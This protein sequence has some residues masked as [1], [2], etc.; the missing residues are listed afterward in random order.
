MIINMRK[1]LVVMIGTIAIAGSLVVQSQCHC[2]GQQSQVL[3]IN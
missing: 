3:I 2:Q 1:L